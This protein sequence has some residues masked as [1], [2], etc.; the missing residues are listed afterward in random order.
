MKIK[1]VFK[2]KLILVSFFSKISE[3][4]SNQILE[5]N[6]EIF[7]LPEFGRIQFEGFN[8][9]I[10]KGLIEE[11]IN[12]P[13]IHDIDQELEFR[14]FGEQYKLAEPSFRERDAVYQSMTYSSDL[15]VPAQLTRGR[16]GKKQRQTVFL[17]SIPLMN[18]QGTFVVNGVARVIINQILRSPGIYYNSELDRNGIPI[19]TGTLISNW[20]GRLKLEIDGKK[21]IWARISKKR[22]VSILILLGAMGLNLKKILVSVS[23]PNIFLESVEKK[24]EKRILF[25]N[26]RSYR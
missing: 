8:R 6:M 5:D 20:G 16:E 12:F 22:K 23:Y 7:V 19:Y 14:I 17:G 13:K 4:S 9:F 11:L 10:N 21:R 18:S 2:I 3:I 26:R 15:Y 1:N 25:F 24:N